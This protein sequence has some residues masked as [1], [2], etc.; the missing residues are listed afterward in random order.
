MIALFLISIFITVI[1]GSNAKKGYKQTDEIDDWNY[2]LVVNRL[3]STA[4]STAV[5]DDPRLPEPKIV[6][7]YFLALVE[8]PRPSGY[9]DKIVPK[10]MEFVEALGFV[11]TKDEIGNII[12]RKNASEGA[13]NWPTIC[14]Q[15]HYDIVAVASPGLEIDFKNYILKP[16]IVDSPDEEYGKYALK[17]TNTSL[18]GDNGIGVALALAVLADSTLKHGPLEILLTMDEET[19]MDGAKELAPG[20]LESQYLINL[21][22]QQYRRIC[23]GCAGGFDDFLHFPVSKDNVTGI[24]ILIE[25]KG[26]KGGHSGLQI[27]LGRANANKVL[28]E[29]VSIVS[30]ATK[31]QNLLAAQ[32]FEGGENATNVI[33]SEARMA[34]IVPADKKDEFLANFQTEVTKLKAEWNT[35]EPDLELTCVADA[36]SDTFVAY[37]PESTQRALDL[38]L[39][40]P[41]GIYRMSP[42]VEG[43]VES[44]YNLARVVLTDEGDAEVRFAY[45]V[46]SSDNFQMPFM[47]ERLE[48]LARVGGGKTD[49]MLN[50]YP[51]WLADTSTNLLQVGKNVYKK[52]NKEEVDVYAMH[53][54]LE[55]G[56]LIG[57]HPN[58][59]C[60]SLGPETWNLHS[61][62]ELLFINT[63]TKFYRLTVGILAELDA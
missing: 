60:I 41:H 23:I 49:G 27:Q 18:G 5:F 44:S 3:F 32:F 61:P 28:A 54:G 31:I 58:L 20:T 21:D 47:H 10:L 62:D 35:I 51:G 1:S 45:R 63:V 53:G 55:P 42:D 24:R 12:V 30:N 7:N 6:W 56:M 50:Y 29:V 13:E 26:L 34:V 25:L 52:L 40:H 38:I 14:L 43:L 9:L 8:T 36:A 46:R 19:T 48:S 16:Q 22:N 33:A 17:A 59:K 11:P 57:S 4:E 37:T 39:V 15:A 2:P